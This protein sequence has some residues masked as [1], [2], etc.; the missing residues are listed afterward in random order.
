MVEA[1]AGVSGFGNWAVVMIESDASGRDEILRDVS[2]IVF[3]MKSEMR[4][5]IGFFDEVERKAFGHFFDDGAGFGIR[6][7]V[8]ED[9]GR[10]ETFSARLMMLDVGNIDTFIAPSVINE[11]F[12]IDAKKL[13]KEFGMIERATSD[14]T[15]GKKI[16]S[17]E[18][19]GV[20][21]TNAPK[22][23]DRLV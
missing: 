14:V 20:A 7:G 22:I 13:V 18:T 21:A 16:T 1:E 3:D 6:V 17:S 2:V 5:E 10:T 8:S 9:L 23:C 11:E 12:G 19:F 15:H 4:S